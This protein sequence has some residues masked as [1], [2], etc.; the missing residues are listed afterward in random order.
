MPGGVWIRVL[1]RGK[2]SPERVDRV[3]TPRSGDRDPRK[4]NPKGQSEKRVKLIWPVIAE[5]PVA[6]S[7]T[8]TPKPEAP[9]MT[10]GWRSM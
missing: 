3:K 4:G 9:T 8:I 2:P 10:V 7:V 6:I 5:P 1:A